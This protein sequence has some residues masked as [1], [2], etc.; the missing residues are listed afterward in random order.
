MMELLQPQEAMLQRGNYFRIGSGVKNKNM[1]YCEYMVNTKIMGLGMVFGAMIGMWIGLSFTGELFS[2][3]NFI[4]GF[5][6]A[7]AGFLT[8]Y[9]FYRWFY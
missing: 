9:Y 2:P 8:V 3:W 6:G 5:F 4:L 1:A 7:I